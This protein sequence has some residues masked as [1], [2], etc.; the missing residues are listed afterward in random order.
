VA[1]HGGDL[2]FAWTIDKGERFEIEFIH[3]LNLSPVVDIFDWTDEGLILRESMFWAIGAGTPTPDDF[4]GSEFLHENG[5]FRLVG[6]DVPMGAFSI[7][8]QDVPNHRVSFGE[9]EAFLLDLVGS[10]QSVT[11][12][13]RRMPVIVTKIFVGSAAFGVPLHLWVLIKENEYVSVFQEKGATAAGCCRW[14][15]CNQTG[16]LRRNRRRGYRR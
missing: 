14:Y 4:P 8:T 5:G 15:G 10:G 3:S 9:R 11:I 1:E 13:V 6:I 2:L 12:E 7:L 16:W